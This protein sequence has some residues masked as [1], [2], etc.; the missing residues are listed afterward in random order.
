MVSYWDSSAILPLLARE[1]DSEQRQTELL[2]NGPMVTWWGTSA[3]LTSALARRHR[4]G[5]LVGPQLA[6]A[7]ARLKVLQE[8][9]TRVMPVEP[10]IR[11]AERL[12]WL[13]PLRSADA[14]QLAAALLAC[15]EDPQQCFFHCAAQRL[16]AAACKEGFQIKGPL[17]I[18]N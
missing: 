18:L 13:H 16:L 2:E 11:R 4:E 15:R 8:Q 5:I 6:S 17:G 1:T 9:W 10:L 7:R 12:L 14:F 3:E